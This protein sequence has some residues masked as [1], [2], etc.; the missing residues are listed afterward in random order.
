MGR[1]RGLLQGRERKRVDRVIAWL[2]RAGIA[3]A[4]L[5]QAVVGL[6][7]AHACAAYAAEEKEKEIM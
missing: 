4:H 7:R 3:I 2:C 6:V 5:K 1:C